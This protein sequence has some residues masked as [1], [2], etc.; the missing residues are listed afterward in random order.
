[1][2]GVE[3]VEDQAYFSGSTAELQRALE[4]GALDRCGS[5]V[6]ERSLIELPA[7]IGRLKR[8]RELVLETD[9]VQTIDPGLF[10]C[11]GLVRLV[12]SSNQI[13]ALP[14][15]GW[16]RMKSLERLELTD[17]NALRAL[18]DDIGDAPK[19]GG[20][21]DLTLLTKLEPLPASFTRLTAVTML[22][23]PPGLLAPD[24]IAGLTGL[25]ELR[26]RAVDRLPADIGALAELRM[27]DASESPVSVLPEIGGCRSMHTLGLGRTN[28]SELPDSLTEL[29]AL[30]DLDLAETPLRVLPADIGRMQLRRIRLQGTQITSLPESL[31]TAAS[32]L[33]IHLPRAH[34]AA[35]EA[36]S[37]PVLRALGHRFTFE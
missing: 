20:E 31:A 28:I 22:C 21:F 9:T 8:L 26:V 3:I 29:A 13:K 14:A 15:G 5:L 6:I 35:I 7:Q 17:S 36:S 27:L 11:T 16:A 1:M 10:A 33:R 34:R 12:I 2:K 19:L 30:R 37:E 24:P 23:L 4:A 18:P 32:D 25:R